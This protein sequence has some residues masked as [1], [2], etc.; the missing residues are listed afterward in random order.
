[1]GIIWQKTV[2]GKQYQVRSAGQTRRLYTDGVFHSQHN[3]GRSLTAN[4]WDLISLPSFFLESN[5]I[6]RILVLGVGGGAV[7]RQFLQ[8]YPGVEITGVELDPMHIRLGKRF[9]GLSNKHVT[10]IEADAIDWVKRYLGLPFDIVIDDLFGEVAGEPQRVIDANTGWLKLLVN[11]LTPHG[12]LVMNFTESR[13]LRDCAVFHNETIQK[14]FN[15]AYRLMTPLY[16][17]QIGVFLRET[18]TANEWRKRISQHPVY[19]EY[20]QSQEK[21]QMRKLRLK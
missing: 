4:V 3:P 17:N 7:I 8:W 15:A 20:R 21:Y 10:L 18:A 5:K 14:N 16:D 9:F 11:L 13:D 1:M 19:R 2:N 12:M 6:R